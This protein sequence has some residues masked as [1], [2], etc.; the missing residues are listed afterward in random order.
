MNDPSFSSAKRF[1]AVVAGFLQL[2]P[3]TSE[4][5][6]RKALRRR[7]PGFID[8]YNTRIRVIAEFEDKTVSVGVGQQARTRSS[9]Q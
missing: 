2:P 8:W 6:V 4:S 9:D 5:G 7:G 1:Q 3:G